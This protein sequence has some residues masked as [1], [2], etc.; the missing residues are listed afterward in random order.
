MLNIFILDLNIL[1]LYF[2]IYVVLERKK[3]MFFLLLSLYNINALFINVSLLVKRCDE[4][5][6]CIHMIR[7][8]FLHY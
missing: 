2:I 3:I 4:S 1:S 5:L 6:D 7:L 8:R